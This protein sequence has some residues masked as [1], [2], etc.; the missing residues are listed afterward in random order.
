MLLV[1]SAFYYMNKADPDCGSSSSGPPGVRSQIGWAIGFIAVF[2]SV[3]VI[4]NLVQ[5]A[6][7]YMLEFLNFNGS[8]DFMVNSTFWVTFVGCLWIVGIAAIVAMGIELSALTQRSSCS[9]RWDRCS[10]SPRGRLSSLH[11]APRR[12][13]ACLPRVVQLAQLSWLKSRRV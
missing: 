5:V 10:S 3:I 8:L 7:L 6:S 1:S 2:A 11:R 13:G 9:C 4:A 12:L